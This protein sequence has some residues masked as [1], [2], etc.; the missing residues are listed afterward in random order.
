[1]AEAHL[2]CGY[3]RV[4]EQ[5]GSSVMNTLPSFEEMM[6]SEKPSELGSESI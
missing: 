4:K 6:T 5:T 3:K 2:A 1:M